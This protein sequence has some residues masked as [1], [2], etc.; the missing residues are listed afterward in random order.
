MKQSY[1]FTLTFLVVALLTMGFQCG[2]DYPIPTPTYE[3][4]E[5]LTL[6]PYRKTYA[7][8]DTIWVQFQ[9]ANKTLFDK[10]SGNRIATD[11]TFLRVN[12]NF[13]RRYPIGNAVEL[14]SETKV[15][16]AFA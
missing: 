5:K 14:F 4:A 13:H 10:L 9:T 12:F 8:G 1:T 2:K 11:T 6:S 16:N 7:V 3:Y 15:D